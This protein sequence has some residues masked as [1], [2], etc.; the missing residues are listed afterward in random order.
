MLNLG[1]L[2][3]AWFDKGPREE[4]DQLLIHEF[5]HHYSGDHLSEAYHDALCSL[6]A[7]LAALALNEPEFWRIHGRGKEGGR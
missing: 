3:H 1:R 6:G 4:V 7:K 2:G 5:G